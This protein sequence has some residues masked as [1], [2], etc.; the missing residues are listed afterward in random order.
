MTYADFAISIMLDTLAVHKPEIVAV[1]KALAKLKKSV[2]EL[3]N[4]E[5]WIATRPD[6][7]H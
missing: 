3:P 6:T 4:I 5:K 2:E 1:F 7:H